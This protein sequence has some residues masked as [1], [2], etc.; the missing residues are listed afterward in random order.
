LKRKPHAGEWLSTMNYKLRTIN[1]EPRTF[2]RLLCGWINHELRTTNYKLFCKTNPISKTP[3][4][5]ITLAKTMTTNHE[6]PTTNHSRTNPNKANFTRLYGG[7]NCPER[8]R[9]AYGEQAITRRTISAQQPRF[10]L[11]KYWLSFIIIEGRFV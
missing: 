3:K 9:R 7:Q 5:I 6:P 4:M 8:S 11:P 2:T 10:P 1:N